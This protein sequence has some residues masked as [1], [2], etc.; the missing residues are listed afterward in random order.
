M[1]YKSLK[2]S[3]AVFMVEIIEHVCREDA[4]R[5]LKEIREDISTSCKITI[6]TPLVS[7]TNLHPTNKFHMIEYSFRD[8]ENILLKCGYKIEGFI[9]EPPVQFTDGE[10]KRQGFFKLGV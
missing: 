5:L 10:Y 2:D 6:T 1:Y 4:M 7:E 9:V 3:T 8:F